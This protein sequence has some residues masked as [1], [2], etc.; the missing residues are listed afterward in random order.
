MFKIYKTL[1]IVYLYMHIRNFK[2]LLK[3]NR[4]SA[5][6]YSSHEMDQEKHKMHV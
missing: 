4:T 5:A 6:T 3:F 2:S 1:V